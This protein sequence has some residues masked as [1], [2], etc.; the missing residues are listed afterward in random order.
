MGTLTDPVG[1]EEFLTRENRI[2]E[3]VYLGLRTTDGLP[4]EEV[5][6][7]R[8]MLW[9]EAGWIRLDHRSDGVRAVCTA[10]GWLRLDALAADLTAFRSA[11]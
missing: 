9:Q 5:E 4:V 1:G 7:S 8:L 11:R 6:L 10:H 3:G 2:A